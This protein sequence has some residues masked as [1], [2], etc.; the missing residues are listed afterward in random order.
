MT[1]VGQ[2]LQKMVKGLGGKDH[3]DKAAVASAWTAA[4]GEEVARHTH[5]RGLRR[6]E[7]LVVVD[8]PVWATQLQAMGDQLKDRVNEEIG[9]TAVR[10]V[11]FNVSSEVQKERDRE[12]AQ[13]ETARGYGGERVEP[14]PLSEVEMKHAES[15]VADIENEELREAA[16]RALVAEKEWQKGAGEQAPE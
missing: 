6:G 9:R 16:L 13:G 5:V 14:Q 15:L 3:A 10:S 11:R 4:T 12:A 7:L 8:S 2:G 1:T